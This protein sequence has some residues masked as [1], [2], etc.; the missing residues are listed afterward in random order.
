MS[1]DAPAVAEPARSLLLKYCCSRNQATEFCISSCSGTVGTKAAAGG[2]S[3][4]Q[5]CY[6]AF[7]TTGPKR[8]LCSEDDPL[9]LRPYGSSCVSLFQ[10]LSFWIPSISQGRKRH[11]LL[12]EAPELWPCDEY[13]PQGTE[14]CEA[15]GSQEEPRTIRQ[16]SC[17]YDKG[18]TGKELQISLSPL[19]LPLRDQI[20]SLSHPG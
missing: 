6:R 3:R 5:L 19:Y 11:G 7:A 12:F 16:E 20:F 18:Q 8:I 10:P 4:Q 13:H 14:G 9:N 17:S 2:R 15:E 1:Y